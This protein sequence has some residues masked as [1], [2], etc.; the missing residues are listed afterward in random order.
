MPDRTCTPSRQEDRELN[1]PS[2]ASPAFCL[3]TRIDVQRLWHLLLVVVSF[4]RMRREA[5][6]VRG[7]LDASIRLRRPRTALLIS[8][9]T[10]RQA[11]DDFESAVLEHPHQVR[12]LR[13]H[14]ATI[15]SGLF[16]LIE[17]SRASVHEQWRGSDAL[18]NDLS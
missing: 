17:L 4:R 9:W 10:G 3:V 8:L 15:W 18:K 2:A 1:R 16:E 11:M 14:R 13:Q 6:M 7:L 12:W 5:R